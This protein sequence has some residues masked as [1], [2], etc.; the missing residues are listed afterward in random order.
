MET[1]TQD[2]TG[3]RRTKT[4]QLGNVT[5]NIHRPMLSDKQQA[6]QAE[7]VKR[8]MLNLLRADKEKEQ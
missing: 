8:A 7:S 6:A 1:W 3:G 2:G 5:V 4:L